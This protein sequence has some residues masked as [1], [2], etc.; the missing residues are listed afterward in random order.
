M[1]HN[2]PT[3]KEVTEGKSWAF[4]RPCLL[5]KKWEEQG[6]SFCLLVSSDLNTLQ[7]DL[8]THLAKSKK[9]NKLLFVCQVFLLRAT[10]R[11]I[12]CSGSAE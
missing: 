9:E 1:K 10:E 8:P 6:I 12:Y 7:L 3:T 4:K 11:V 5:P 2:L